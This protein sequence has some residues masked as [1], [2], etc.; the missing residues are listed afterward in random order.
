VHDVP[1]LVNLAVAL[2]YALIGGLLARRLGLPTI[3]GYMLAGV[4]LGPFTPGF[5]GDDAAIRQMAEFGVI[6]LMFGVGLHFSFRDLWQVRRIVIPG[7]LLQMLVVAA[8]AAW[9]GRL[10]GFSTGAAW[11]FGV[12]VAVTSTV[13]L[14]RALMDHGWLDTPAGK[15]AVGWLVVEDLLTVAVLVLMPVVAGPG[16]GSWTAG[17]FAVG[18]ALLF[19]VLMMLVGDYVVPALLG[20]VVHLRS[21]ELFVLAALTLAIG[22]AL[23]SSAYFGVSLALGAFVAGLVVGESPFSHQVGADLLPFREAFAVVFFVSV[24]MLVDPREL[25][26]HW[27][28]VGVVTLLIVVVKGVVSGVLGVLLGC[29]G[30]TVLVLAAGRGQIG[31]FSFIVGQSGLAL[32]LL[33]VSQ[34]SLILAGAIISI[35]VN[36][37]LVRLVEPAERWLKRKPRVWRVIDGVSRANAGMPE[38]E[39]EIA[40]HVV[41]VGCGRVGRHIAEALGRLGIPRLVVEA[42][43][44]RL[45]KLRTLGVP[46]LFGDAGSSD[47]LENAHLD[48]ARAVVI[49]LPDDAA[50]LAV[51]ATARKLA[52][53]L[54]IVAR[55]STWEGARRLKADGVNQVVRPELEGGVEIVRRTLLDLDLPV[56]EVQRYTDLVRREGLDE[57]ERPSPGQARVLEDLVQ[58]SKDLE[59]GWVVVEPGSAVAGRALSDTLLRATAGVTVIAIARQHE[60]LHNPAA[61]EVLQPGDRV[62]LIGTPAQVSAAERFFERFHQ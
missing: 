51:V 47:I 38:P 54:P 27:D 2:G 62:A 59:V 31:E 55:A 11:T 30:R 58:A 22:T 42:D 1:L 41:I 37:F 28:H 25:L 17:L 26:K 48:R 60:L 12:A 50:A 46:V 24:G 36:P 18:A 57:A 14:M 35:T 4:A 40:Q 39:P 29:A 13:V 53:K 56:R 9:V 16:P 10:Y 20:R 43:P 32:G 61:Q 21:R 6:L 7:A 15:V 44:I 23:V 49:T 5:R 45:D 19:V 33:D 3:V 8:L 52:P 34:Y